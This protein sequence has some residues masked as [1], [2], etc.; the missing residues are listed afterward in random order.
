MSSDVGVTLS[1]GCRITHGRGA[2]IKKPFSD[3]D[4]TM[5]ELSPGNQKGFRGQ[6]GFIEFTPELRL[7]RHVHMDAS[8]ERLLDERILVLHGVGVVEIAGKVWATAPGTLVD[9]TGGIPHTWSA[10]PA[11]VKLS[12]G[13]VS[14]GKFTMVFEYEEP[15]SFFPTR[16]TETVTNVAQYQPFDGDNFDEIRFPKLTAQQVA[17]QA[18]IVFD[19]QQQRLSLP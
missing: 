13:S 7:P 15:T 4:L 18:E 14:E 3:I 10:C 19:K 1:N 5:H 11:G 12:D 17:E 6:L 8:K 2:N 16:S 9:I